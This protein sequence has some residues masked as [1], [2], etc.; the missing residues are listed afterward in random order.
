MSERQASNFRQGQFTSA[1]VQALNILGLN[2]VH[3]L[4]EEPINIWGEFDSKGRPITYKVDICIND[5][6]FGAGIIEIDGEI[7]KKLKHEIKDEKRD[8]RL[9]FQG[10]WVEHILNEEVKDVMQVLERHRRERDAYS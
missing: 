9:S 6:Y 10:F 1:H 8:Q 3:Y 7:H 4:A 5:P 2:H